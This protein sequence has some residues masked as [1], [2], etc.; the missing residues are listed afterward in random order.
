MADIGK[1]QISRDK[2]PNE[3]AEKIIFVADVTP[4]HN[5]KTEVLITGTTTGTIGTA[6]TILVTPTD[7][8]FYLTGMVLSH[9]QDAT[10]TNT[11]AYIRNSDGTQYYIRVATITSLAQNNSVT[12]TFK[13]SFLCQR[14]K[15]IQVGVNITDGV[16]LANAT[17]T[18]YYIDNSRA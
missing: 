5:R 14:G 18:G 8:D 10:S 17:I 11:G 4:D 1:I 9:S 13:E 2:L 16:Q 6:G 7:R 3:F 15:T 12:F